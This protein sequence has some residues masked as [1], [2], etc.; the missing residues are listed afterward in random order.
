MQCMNERGDIHFPSIKFGV[1]IKNLPVCVCVCVRVCGC[2]YLCPQGP[3]VQS[4][5]HIAHFK[6]PHQL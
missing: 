1:L 6:S 3:I 2:V 5:G 4:I